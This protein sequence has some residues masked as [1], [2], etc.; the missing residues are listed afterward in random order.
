MTP[1]FDQDK[2][3]QVAVLAVDIT[4]RKQ[5]EE[6][7]EESE[8]RFRD[9]TENA[10]EWVWEMDAQGKYTYSSPMVEQLL[11]YKP[12]EILGKYFYDFFLPEVREELSER[13]AGGIRC[14][15]A[16]TRLSQPQPA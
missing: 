8:K 5:A 3:V 16:I 11:G 13:C 6:A 10:A 7:L 9:I 2:V 12:E 15:T 14:Q 4:V 1:I